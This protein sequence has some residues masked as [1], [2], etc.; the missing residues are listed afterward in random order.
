[1]SRYTISD[2]AGEFGITTRAI[3]FY[4]EKGLLAPERNGTQRLYS[5]AD[6]VRLKLILRGKRIGLSLDESR[7]IIDMY[8]PS[9]ANNADQLQKLIN[10]TEEKRAQFQAQMRDLQSTLN[11]LNNVQREAEAAL[12]ELTQSTTTLKKKAGE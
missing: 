11:D 12:Q 10:K 1:M 7:D 4:E 9:G 8:E 3:R 6:R 2:L 5:P